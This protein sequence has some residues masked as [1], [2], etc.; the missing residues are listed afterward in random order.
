MR[1]FFELIRRHRFNT[2]FKTCTTPRTG[3]MQQVTKWQNVKDIRLQSKTIICQRNLCDRQQNTTKQNA[4]YQHVLI[5][6]NPK[7]DTLRLSY[8]IPFVINSFWIGCLCCE[9]EFITPLPVPYIPLSTKLA[10]QQTRRN[11][12]KRTSANPLRTAAAKKTPP[13]IHTQQNIMSHT[14]SIEK[15]NIENL[16]KMRIYHCEKELRL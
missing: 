11:E 13:T 4:K 6:S 5:N 16:P 14:F 9:V 8:E 3:F 2:E 15:K 1:H 10:R 7:I 12:T